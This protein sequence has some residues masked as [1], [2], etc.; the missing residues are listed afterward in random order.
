VGPDARLEMS[1]LTFGSNHCLQYVYGYVVV[2][3]GHT[4]HVINMNQQSDSMDLLGG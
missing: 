2:Y 1:K 3:V 4:L